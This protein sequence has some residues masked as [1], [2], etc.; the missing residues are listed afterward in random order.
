MRSLNLPQFRRVRLSSKQGIIFGAV[1]GSTTILDGCP[2][3]A[4]AYMGRKRRGAAPSTLLLCE[5]KDCCSRR[6]SS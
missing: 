5:Q 6:E 4:P 3:F 2:M 1:L